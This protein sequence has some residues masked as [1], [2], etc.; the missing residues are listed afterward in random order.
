MRKSTSGLYIGTIAGRQVRAE[1]IAEHKRTKAAERFQ[2]QAA[3]DQLSMP[4]L[5]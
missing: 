5:R 4:T 3:L 1:K 2:K